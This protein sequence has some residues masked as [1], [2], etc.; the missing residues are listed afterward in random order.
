MNIVEYVMLKNDSNFVP[1]KYLVMHPAVGS[2]SDG[3]NTYVWLKCTACGID[4]EVNL[5]I[6]LSN[7]SEVWRN[8]NFPDIATFI[9][10]K[11]GAS[12]Y[13]QP[14]FFRQKEVVLVNSPGPNYNDP[15]LTSSSPQPN[16][17][18]S[19][20]QSDASFGAVP[21]TGR[22]VLVLTQGTGVVEGADWEYKDQFAIATNIKGTI[23]TYTVQSLSNL[24]TYVSGHDPI[25]NGSFPIG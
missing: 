9:A 19:A 14:Y 2:A 5:E 17:I 25:M 1:V 24:Q 21:V 11:S 13:P 7:M 23:G 4:T 8:N 3:G 16:P 18:Q 20:Q 6:Y 12:P 22:K 10:A 15:N